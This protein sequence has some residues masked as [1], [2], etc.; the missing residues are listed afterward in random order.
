[1]S[2]QATDAERVQ[3]DPLPKSLYDRLM[4]VA[5][6]H[7]VDVDVLADY[8]LRNPSDPKVYVDGRTIRALAAPDSFTGAAPSFVDCRV[9]R[10][11]CPSAF[12]FRGTWRCGCPKAS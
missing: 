5:V 3:L 9:R 1:M 6:R 11:T 7:G 10:G 12:K 2:L 4:T 8:I